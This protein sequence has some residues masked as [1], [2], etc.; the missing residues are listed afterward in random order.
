M[1][2]LTPFKFEKIGDFMRQ[3]CRNREKCDRMARDS[4][5]A[6][7]EFS[8]V[9]R[10]PPGHKIVVHLD[11]QNVTHVIIPLKREIEAA[12]A[13]FTFDTPEHRVYP[14]EYK[15]SP[16]SHIVETAE[17]LRAFSFILG[18]YTMRRCKN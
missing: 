14:K 16:L 1:A 5:F 8:S 7:E 11:E 2:N 17:P 4:D 13:S 18:E 9:V 6:T 15:M 3:L 12:E 10:I